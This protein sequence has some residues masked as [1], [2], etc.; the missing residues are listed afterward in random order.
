[1][2][3]KVTLLK[4]PYSVKQDVPYHVREISIANQEVPG[5]FS[6]T[7][8]YYGNVAISREELAALSLPPKFAVYSNINVAYCEV[9]VDKWL[10]KYSWSVRNNEA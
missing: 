1:M 2:S 3:K 10:A 5:A 6:T 8:P 4:S 7:P 9:Q